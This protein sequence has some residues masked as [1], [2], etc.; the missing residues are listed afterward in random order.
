[1]VSGRPGSCT[2]LCAKD[3]KVQNADRCRSGLKSGPG[4]TPALR[5]S[6]VGTS[7]AFEHD[8]DRLCRAL[9][10]APTRAERRAGG[11]SATLGSHAPSTMGN[12]HWM[13][14]RSRAQ[15]I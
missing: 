15:W 11:A 7:L 8:Q 1:M 12:V 3:V 5:R 4:F 9:V 10:S 6:F 14:G 13:T 2:Y